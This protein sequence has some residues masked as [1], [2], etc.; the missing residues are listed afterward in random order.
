MSPRFHNQDGR[1]PCDWREWV[2]GLIAV[3]VIL[4][5]WYVLFRW[6]GA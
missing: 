6:I 5:V 3:A 4:G 2:G 1:G